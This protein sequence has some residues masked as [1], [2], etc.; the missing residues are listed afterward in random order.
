MS[1]KVKR[2]G[3]Y[4]AN[5]SP[6]IEN[7]LEIQCPECGKSIIARLNCSET[8]SYLGKNLMIVKYSEMCPDCRC[9][10]EDKVKY[11]LGGRDIKSCVFNI[12]ST[13]FCIS[14]FALIVLALVVQASKTTLVSALI[15]VFF[16]L[17]LI[18]AVIASFSNDN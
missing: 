3:K 2:H 4:Y 15:I 7:R 6:V 11:N 18:S 12:S 10:F 1:V 5:L 9:V 17:L 16:V 14:L 8:T 13:C